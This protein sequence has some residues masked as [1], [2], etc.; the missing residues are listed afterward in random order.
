MLGGERRGESER[1]DIR[2]ITRCWIGGYIDGFRWVGV[3]LVVK[4]SKADTPITKQH[5]LTSSSDA[6]CVVILVENLD[7]NKIEI[8][9]FI[10]VG[11]PY[12]VHSRSLTGN[13]E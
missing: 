12:L 5:F 9:A 3:M 13:H 4:Q 1:E 8:L 11:W 10:L 6:V 7:E 2:R